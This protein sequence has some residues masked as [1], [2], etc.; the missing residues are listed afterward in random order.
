MTIRFW[1]G[2]LQPRIRSSVRFRYGFLQPRIRLRIRFQ[3]N[4]LCARSRLRTVSRR[5]S[6]KDISPAAAPAPS[7]DIQG[8]PEGEQAA[9]LFRIHEDVV[10]QAVAGDAHHP[11]TQDG[12]PVLYSSDRDHGVN[13]K[14]D[15][16]KDQTVVDQHLHIGAVDIK[17]IGGLQ[18]SV[19]VNDLAEGMD[20]VPFQPLCRMTDAEMC[21]LVIDLE[22]FLVIPVV[23]GNHLI[24]KKR[25]HRITYTREKPHQ[26]AVRKQVDPAI[27]TDQIKKHK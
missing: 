22:P 4:S 23:A 15:N 12:I 1:Y 3:Y 17:I 27:E 8:I 2:F 9:A 11:D 24:S 5:R 19:L 14:Q 18:V 6:G 10:H 7:H 26:S 20:A 16:C 13:A 25:Q 21:Q